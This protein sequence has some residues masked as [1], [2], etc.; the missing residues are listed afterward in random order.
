VWF[1]VTD[2]RAPLTIYWDAELLQHE[3]TVRFATYGRGLWDLRLAPQ[4]EGCFATRDSDGDGAVCADDCDDEQPLAAPGL[5]EVECDGFDNNCDG[6]EMCP[7]EPPPAQGDRA[8]EDK[9]GCGCASGPAPSLLGLLALAL[10]AASR[11]SPRGCR[12]RRSRGP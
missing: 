7:P 2:H 12:P 3:N 1:P 9:E 11:C 4:G 5:E 8:S 10:T 6:A